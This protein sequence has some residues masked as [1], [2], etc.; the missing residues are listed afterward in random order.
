[1]IALHPHLLS[2]MAHRLSIYETLVHKSIRI[3]LVN[4]EIHRP[5]HIANCIDL[6]YYPFI[7]LRSIISK[8]DTLINV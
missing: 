8:V 2:T 3:F 5:K 7:V 4:K 1:M 6:Y